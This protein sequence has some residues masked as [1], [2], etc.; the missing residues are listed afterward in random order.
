MQEDMV[1]YAVLWWLTPWQ[2]VLK[3]ATIINVT[4]LRQFQDS[5]LQEL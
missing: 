4:W 5:S 2:A 1:L 3:I